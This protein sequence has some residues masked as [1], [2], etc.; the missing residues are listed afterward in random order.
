MKEA[1]A[2]GGKARL[3]LADDGLL[4]LRWGEG[5]HVSAEEARQALALVEE[6]SA[7]RRYPMLADMANMEIT[8]EARQ[9]FGSA[10]VASKVALVGQS[11]VDRLMAGF[12]LKVYRPPSPTRFFAEEADAVQWLRE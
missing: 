1:T 3:T 12:F 10:G 4:Y 7:G 5:V 8:R 6:M 11:A 2:A 9:V